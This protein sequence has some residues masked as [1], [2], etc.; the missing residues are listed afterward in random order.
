MRNR[1]QDG[2]RPSADA[3]ARTTVIGAVA[4]SPVIVV[5][6]NVRPSAVTS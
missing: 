2:R 3:Q 5:M 1:D 4:L 6:T